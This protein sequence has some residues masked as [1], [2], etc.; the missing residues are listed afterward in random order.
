MVNYLQIR[1]V[2][3]ESIAPNFLHAPVVKRQ[4]FYKC[5]PT[6][7]F[8][9]RKEYI[10]PA[11]PLEHSVKRKPL[12]AGSESDLSQGQDV[13]ATLLLASACRE[14][15]V[16]LTVMQQL[17]A[18]A[19]HTGY[20]YYALPLVGHSYTYVCYLK[21]HAQAQLTHAMR[22]SFNVVYYL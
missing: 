4:Q 2:V 19:T 9:F 12:I 13:G 11:T 15:I 10:M 6:T 16:G 3:F 21:H 17:L 7:H 22:I 8:I 5:M 1:E 18:A 20:F 14:R